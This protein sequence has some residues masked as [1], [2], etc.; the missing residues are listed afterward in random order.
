MK[1][2]RA[3]RA[4]LLCWL[5]LAGMGCG[6]SGSRDVKIEQRGADGGSADQGGAGGFG[7]GSGGASGGGGADAGGATGGTQPAGG[8]A[9]SAGGAGGSKPVDPARDAAPAVVDA[10]DV[11]G[12]S[13]ARPPDVVADTNAPD[14]PGGPADVAES[15]TTAMPGAFINTGMPSQAGVFT[16]ELH[17]T[18]SA[19]PTNSIVALS[20]G[21]QTTYIGYAL[22]A[23]FNPSGMIDAVNGTQY[24]AAA[25][26]PY[27]ATTRYRFRFVVNV[28]AHTYSA[29]VTP[30][31]GSELT[32]G[33]N[34]PFRSTQ[35]TVTSLN[36]W[37]VVSHATAPGPTTACGFA[38][39]SGP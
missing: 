6:P 7:G 17:A 30:A 20:D 14:G 35:N 9:G 2:P 29:Y 19:A 34:L 25:P 1:F 10:A 38:V 5:T 36:S 18:P 15:C 32:I 13:D 22:A 24:E 23:R 4:P 37:G 31:G 3:A 26:I 16:A 8:Q 27:A 28:P 12:G 39:R 33:T 11:G 21:P